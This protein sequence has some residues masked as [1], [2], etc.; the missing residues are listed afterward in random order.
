M[1]KTINILTNLQLIQLQLSLQIRENGQYMS[2]NI[3]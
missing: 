3:R 1:N 2:K